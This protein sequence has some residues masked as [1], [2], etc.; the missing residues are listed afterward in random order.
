MTT[1]TRD[2][3]KIIMKSVLDFGIQ[4]CGLYFR[5]RNGKAKSWERVPA[6]KWSVPGIMIVYDRDHSHDDTLKAPQNRYLE[7]DSLIPFM[8]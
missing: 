2:H 7:K 5:L 1:A 4:S 3:N 6:L 8:H